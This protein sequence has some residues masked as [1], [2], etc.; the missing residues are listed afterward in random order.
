MFLTDLIETNEN[1][2]ISYS[3]SSASI[4]SYSRPWDAF[5]TFFTSTFSNPVF[6]YISRHHAL[7][8]TIAISKSYAYIAMGNE[9]NMQ[10]TS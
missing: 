4:N 1:Q 9:L 3:A 10:S 7:L 6:L 2:L 5:Q 8:I